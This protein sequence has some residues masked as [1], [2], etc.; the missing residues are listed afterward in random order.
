MEEVDLRGIKPSCAWGYYVVDGRDGTYLGLSG[1]FVSFNLL[2]QFED[3]L[4]GEDETHLPLELWDE[5]LQ[6]W[7]GSAVLLEE[8]II[9]ACR[10]QFLR[11]EFDNILKE[12]LRE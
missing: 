12:G 8:L 11:L 4:I 1:N 3:W 2:L 10:V 9:L 7:P 5:R 6:L